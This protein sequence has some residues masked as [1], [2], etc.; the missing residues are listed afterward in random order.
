M[1]S[2]GRVGEAGEAGVG[3]AFL[4]N[5]SGLGAP[6]LPLVIWYLARGTGQVDCSLE[7]ESP[8]ME[9][10]GARVRSGFA[11]EK[12]VHGSLEID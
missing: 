9:A 3:L 1:V 11:F 4:N 6:R 7:F 2:A 5:F 10:F 12:C 8:I